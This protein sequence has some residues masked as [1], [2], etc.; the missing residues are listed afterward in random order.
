[1]ASYAG[2]R[3]SKVQVFQN[4]RLIGEFGSVNSCSLTYFPNK[5]NT[6]LHALFDGQKE[7]YSK[8]LNLLF[9]KFEKKGYL[10]PNNSLCSR[11]NVYDKQKNE[12]IKIISTKE[13]KKYLTVNGR[14][15][16][17]LNRNGIYEDENFRIW[18]AE[19]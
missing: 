11:Y 18:K 6:Y 19:K 15:Y 12:K 17:Q 3:P 14:F 13:L 1:M 4:D 2:W 10:K 5:A 16:R 8:K 7:Y 9:V